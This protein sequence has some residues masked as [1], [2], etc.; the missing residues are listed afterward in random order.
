MSFYDRADK[1]LKV[2]GMILPPD[3]RQLLKDMAAAIDTLQ[4]SHPQ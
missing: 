3:I 4:R 1:A 2:Y